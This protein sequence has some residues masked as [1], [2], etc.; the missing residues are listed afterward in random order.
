MIRTARSAVR[1]LM[2]VV[3]QHLCTSA[4]PRSKAPRTT[5]ANKGLRFRD[6]GDFRLVSPCRSL[7]RGFREWL[8]K[9]FGRVPLASSHS[10]SQNIL[11]LRLLWKQIKGDRLNLGY[12]G[13]FLDCGKD[14][15]VARQRFFNDAVVLILAGIL[16][17]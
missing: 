5:L 12:R 14:L 17:H 11:V 15:G 8:K 16:T 13:Q 4:L 9:S 3:R 10:S 6:R 1:K 2:S 7:L